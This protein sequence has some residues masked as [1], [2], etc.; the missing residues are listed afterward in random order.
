MPDYSLAGRSSLFVNMERKITAGTP[1]GGMLRAETR[2]EN[3]S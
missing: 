2:S 1:N 3:S